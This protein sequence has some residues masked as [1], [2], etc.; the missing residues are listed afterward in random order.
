[1]DDVE[2]DDGDGG[3][4]NT[5]DDSSDSDGMDDDEHNMQNGEESDGNSI[6]DMLEEQQM[7]HQADGVDGW[8]TD[9][10]SVEEGE[11]LDEDESNEDEFGGFPQ[12]PI[13]V[14][15]D[16]LD[17]SEDDLDDGAEDLDE[18]REL[19]GNLE[20]QI[21]DPEPDDDEDEHMHHPDA[22]ID[23]N[24]RTTHIMRTSGNRLLGVTNLRAFSLSGWS[25]HEQSSSFYCSPIRYGKSSVGTNLL[26]A[27]HL[28]R[29]HLPVY[30]Q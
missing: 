15:D 6:I 12:P 27:S 2:D 29:L 30:I 16:D 10:D 20:G 18:V 13:P 26:Q 5:S 19:M 4:Q 9:T 23:M 24:P 14:D 28:L 3:S 7:E 21:F 25:F 17:Y 1:M 22:W 11:E 8:T